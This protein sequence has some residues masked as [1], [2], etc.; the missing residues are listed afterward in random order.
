VSYFTLARNNAACSSARR[1][2]LSAVFAVSITGHA[3]SVASY[4]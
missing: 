3:A 4:I 1:P 2:N